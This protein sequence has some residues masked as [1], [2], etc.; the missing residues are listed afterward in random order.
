MADEADRSDHRII[1][2]VEA[3]IEE[4]RLKVKPIKHYT[5]CQ[6]CWDET[7]DGAK[8]CDKDCKTDHER[9]KSARTRNDGVEA[10]D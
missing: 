1:A 3:G 10:E 6:W 5:H 9:Y 2:V 7:I 4:A 8:Y